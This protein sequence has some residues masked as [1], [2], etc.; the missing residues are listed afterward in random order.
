MALKDWEKI[1]TTLYINKM[2]N[3][4][5]KIVES[6]DMFAVAVSGEGYIT[7]D[8]MLTKSQATK[9]ALRYMRTH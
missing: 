1:R 2:N 7:G 3:K 9:E 5:L 4:R 6:M 8:D